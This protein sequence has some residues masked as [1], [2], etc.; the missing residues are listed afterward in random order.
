VD[1]YFYAQA[2]IAYKIDPISGIPASSS[3]RL[4]ADH[5]LPYG[6]QVKAGQYLTEFASPTRR[7][8][9]PGTGWTSP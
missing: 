2:N 7:T 9:T 1:P 3:K 8:R 6:L 5:S 4:R